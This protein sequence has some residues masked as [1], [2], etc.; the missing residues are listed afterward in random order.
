MADLYDDLDTSV[1]G[2]SSVHL[3][4]ELRVVQEQYDK[5]KKEAALLQRLNK[6]L[7][8]QNAI[9]ETNLSTVFATAQ[10]EISRKDKTIQELRDELHEANSRWPHQG[11]DAFSRRDRPSPG[12]SH[13]D[14]H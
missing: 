2:R 3:K 4:K 5:L 6:E 9:L 7:A 11:R 13:R 14:R 8:E 12:A 10:T 1:D